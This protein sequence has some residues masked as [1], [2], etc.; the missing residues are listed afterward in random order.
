MTYVR[1]TGGRDRG[2][3]KDMAFPMA[4]EML[5]LGQALPVNF[6]EADPLGFRELPKPEAIEPEPIYPRLIKRH[7]PVAEIPVARPE[8]KKRR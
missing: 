5:A 2:E 4:Q 6:D 1:L 8:G 7:E 3:V